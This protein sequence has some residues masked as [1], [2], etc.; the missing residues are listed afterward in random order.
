MKEPRAKSQVTTRRR[1]KQDPGP[2]LPL[3]PAKAPP[4]DKVFRRKDRGGRLYLRL[5]IQSGDFRQTIVRS[6]RTAT[7][8]AAKQL[9]RMYQRQHG[10]AAA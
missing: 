10:K 9:L 8:A 5:H 4:Q 6:A 1:R 2:P 7:T 3:K